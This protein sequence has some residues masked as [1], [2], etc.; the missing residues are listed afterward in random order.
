MFIIKNILKYFEIILFILINLF[1]SFYSYSNDLFLGLFSKFSGNFILSDNP[2]SIT[3][4]VGALL[5]IIISN[6]VYV[7]VKLLSVTIFY[8][9]GFVLTNTKQF[10]DKLFYNKFYTLKFM[11]I[12]LLMDIIFFLIRIIYSQN[13]IYEIV[14]SYL[15]S[16]GGIFPAYIVFFVVFSYKFIDKTIIK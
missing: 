12:I 7:V 10:L 2:D 13:N 6:I 4:L 14:K 3:A 15:L 1:F 16:V 5:L 9:L 8:C 11:L